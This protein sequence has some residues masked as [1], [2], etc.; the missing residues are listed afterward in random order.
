MLDQA[1]R[2][3]AC[4]L[5]TPPPEAGI[6]RSERPEAPLSQDDDAPHRHPE[7]SVPWPEHSE[8]ID[9]LPELVRAGSITR[10][11]PSTTVAMHTAHMLMLD[12]PARPGFENG[13]LRGADDVNSPAALVL[14]DEGPRS[15]NPSSQSNTLSELVRA[16]PA[17]V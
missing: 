10:L 1:A 15:S 9:S 16:D 12:Q 7:I 14:V 13:L 3:P 4:A 17:P 2:A 8:E 6:V 5:G 11:E